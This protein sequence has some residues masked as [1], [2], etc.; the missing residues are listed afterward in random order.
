[1]LSD[2]GYTNKEI[3]LIYLDHIILHTNAGLN[4]PPKVLLMDQHSSHID[5]EFTL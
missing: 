2:S 1:V 5:P 4:K 3:S